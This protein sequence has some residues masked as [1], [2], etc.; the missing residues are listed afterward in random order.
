M[1]GADEDKELAFP[2]FINFQFCE[3]SQ[4]TVHPSPEELHGRIDMGK[5][6]K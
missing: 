3:N 6:N 5:P 2:F 1:L 4:S